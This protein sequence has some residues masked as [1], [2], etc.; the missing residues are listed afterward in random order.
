MSSK[1]VLHVAEPCHQRWHEMSPAEQGRFC[2]GCSKKVID[3]TGKTDRQ[4]LALLS[5]ESATTCGRFSESQLQRPLNGDQQFAIKPYRFLFAALVPAF[6]F[7]GLATAQQKET[8]KKG[9][10][11]PSTIEQAILMGNFT[12]RRVNEPAGE[13]K[14]ITMVS[15]KVLNEEGEPVPSAPVWVTG[16]QN[17]T[18][19]DEHGR[20]MLSLWKAAVSVPLS[21][22]AIGSKTVQQHVQ[23]S[24]GTTETIFRLIDEPVE[25][26]KALTGR[27]ASTCIAIM[28]EIAM[29]KK[30]SIADTVRSMVARLTGTQMFAVFPNP[31]VAG[32]EFHLVFKTPGK[33]TVRLFSSSGHL[34]HSKAFSVGESQRI[35]SLNISGAVP[36]GSYY[37]EASETQTGKRYSTKVIVQ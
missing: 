1:I 10:N 32:G 30:P 28:G 24:E 34:Y 23:A 3:F 35:S 20:F 37:L 16:T 31:A 5:Q 4:I 21:A 15:G 18:T 27:E 12:P 6:L 17:G 26:C 33:Y 29:V 9:S 7:N 8:I 25:T 36:K 22:T 13:T 2:S 19:T 14:P 11:K